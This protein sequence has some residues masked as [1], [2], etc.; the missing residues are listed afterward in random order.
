M[1]FT[2]IGIKSGYSLMN[3]TIDIHELIDE[4]YGRGIKALGLVD[5]KNISAWL[6]FY[7]ACIE[8]NITP[9]LGVELPV[10]HKGEE[11]PTFLLATSE[12][13]AGNV[14]EITSR[15]HLDGRVELNG[16]EELGNDVIAI[17][18]TG[19]TPVAQQVTENRKE[20]VIPVYREFESVFSLMFA[21]VRA[22]ELR[23]EQMLHDP[24][25][26]WAQAGLI[27]CTAISDVH[28]LK[29]EDRTAYEV[30]QAMEAGEAFKAG[31]SSP[32]VTCLEDPSRTES[33]FSEWPEVIRNNETIVDKSSVSLTRSRSLLPSYPLEDGDSN[34]YLRE[35]CEQ[36]LPEKYGADTGEAKKRLEHELEV[37]TSR[38]FSDYFLIVWDFVKYAK[39]KGIKVGPGRGSAAGSIVAYLLN[40][41]TVDPLKYGLLFERFLN[42][43]RQTMPDIDIDFSDHRRDE[44]I[45]YVREKYGKERVAQI[46]T[47]GTFAARS[48][49]REV[50]KA[51][52]VEEEDIAY[53][54][55]QF[56]G[57]RSLN[58]EQIVK[59]SEPLKEFIRSSGQLQSLFRIGTR[60]EGLPRHVS[61]HAAGVVI[62]D[63][64][65]GR[66]TGMM[67]H[68]GPALLTQMAM[69]DVEAS[70]LLKMDFLG[71]RN[72][73]FLE[74]MEKNIRKYA[75][76][77]FSIQ[78]IPEDDETTYRQLSEGKTNGIFQLE[79]RGM[80]KVLQQLKP[81]RF[82]DIV[83]VNALYRPG[84]MDFIPDYVERKHGRTPVTYLHADIEP[85]L[86]ETYGVLL[87]QEQIMKVAQIVAGYSL[88]EA[89]LF[90]RAVS[91]KQESILK[92]EES[93][94]LKGAEQAGYKEEVA[95][96]L[97]RWIVKFSNYGFN[98]SHAVAYSIISYKLAYIKT[99]FPEYFLSELIN[100]AVGDK[101]KIANYVREAK[102]EGI[103][104]HPPFVNEAFPHT[105]VRK[106][107]IILGFMMIKGIGFKM[108]RSITEERQ[109]GRFTN[110]FEFTMRGSS[111]LDRNSM[112]NLIKAGCFD[113]L[114]SNR[115]SLLASIDQ[116]LEQSELFR[117]FQEDIG[118]IT[119]W[120]GGLVH[121]DPLPALTRLNLEKEVLGAVLSSHPLEG[122]GK[123]LKR[124]NIELLS[125]ALMKEKGFITVAAVVDNVR[126]IRTKRGEKMA[127][128]SLSDDKEEMDAVVFPETYR[129]CSSWLDEDMIVVIGGK[130]QERRGEKQLQAQSIRPVQE[131]SEIFIKTEK[132]RY[133]EVLEFM[134]TLARDHPGE[135]EIFL[136]I[137]EVKK[138]YK[139][140][141]GYGIDV[142]EE[143]RK[144][145]EKNIGNE[146]YAIRHRW[147]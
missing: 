72:L 54:L 96:E 77:A 84:P 56:P 27:S 112:E 98:K 14:I 52:K 19:D 75:D 132:K 91:K 50:G 21:G 108:G 16:I 68:D 104:V 129:T 111:Y 39:D 60:I 31:T 36:A 85:I 2:H 138:V 20:E 53:I 135:Q 8:K 145:L 76:S 83:A 67:D 61:T 109:R 126:E 127:F 5:E 74:N 17:W 82:E 78:S 43:E 79:S 30:M 144:R 22:A 49:I 46:C 37:I 38:K 142:S 87:Y 48:T 105:S 45:T 35:L 119:E 121:K 71:L 32:G 106:G 34:E 66:Y 134:K 110:F 143:V 24:L 107:N 146:K 4:A 63:Y 92:N 125:A 13:G 51:L 81:E 64:P 120:S 114:H 90:R 40:I 147:L 94:F 140:P 130:I 102:Q 15:Y 65:L 131:T 23:Q 124:N 86:E 69:E 100:S 6:S 44:V 58:L 99:H 117:E 7:N 103:P 26:A 118:F 57:N 62:S 101:E 3:S 1:G 123:S 9:I 41:T 89:D 136:Y 95:R 137:E 18:K 29:E 97:F 116:A 59:Q 133:T 141:S 93:R 70:G 80:R 28:F 73:S 33:Y 55:K 12:Q 47:F 139:M 42:P 10:I 11:Y 113:R 122:A 115:A 88:G 25:K 128:L